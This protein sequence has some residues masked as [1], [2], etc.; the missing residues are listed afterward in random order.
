MKEKFSKFKNNFCLGVDFVKNY[1]MF[2]IHKYFF[3][4]TAIII[5]CLS[6]CARFSVALHPTQDVVGYVFKW[7]KDIKTVGF[8]SF[9]TVQSD[10]SPL[11]LFIIGIYTL[12]PSGELIKIGSHTFYENW[13]YYVKGTYFFVEILIAIGIFLVIKTITNDKKYAWLGYVTFLCLPVQFFN[14]AVW[15]NADTMYFACFIYVI[16]FALRGKDG[17]AF[18]ITGISFGL[19]LQ[20]VF[21][22]PFLVYMLVSGKMKFYK[23]IFAPLGL[24]ATF[25]PAYLFGAGLFEPFKFF[26]EQIN[27]YK[28]LTL[29]CANIWHLIN[30]RAKNLETFESG[31]TIFGLLLIGLFCAIVFARKIKLNNEAI[32]LVATFLIS[33][34][35]MFLPH[36]HERYFYSLDVLIL[37]YCLVAK[38]HYFL[39]VLMQLSSGI[40]YHNY[41]AGRHFIIS[42]GEDSVNI[43]SWINIA[44]LCVLFYD[45]LKLETDG[46]INSHT[47]KYKAKICELKDKFSNNIKIDK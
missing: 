42:W 28:K 4:I 5:T 20:A 40:A 19:K 24:F 21:I 46:D 43:A 9:Y 30:L 6:L 22:L 34:V 18:F 23:L 36:M 37:V 25:I 2:F 15:G 8:G 41:L 13:M 47:D 11:F 17:L 35:P 12:L 32:L 7:M 14:S 3:L 45:V 33:I 26:S 31:A 29:G 16:Y 1:F 27:G 38:K 39:I 44:V 10:Y